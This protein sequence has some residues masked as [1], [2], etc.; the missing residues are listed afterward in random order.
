MKPVMGLLEFTLTI[1]DA[2]SFNIQFLDLKYTLV[3]RKRLIITT[4]LYK[5]GIDS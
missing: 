2:L 4:G 3:F 1:K 5:G